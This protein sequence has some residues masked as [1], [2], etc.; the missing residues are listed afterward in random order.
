MVYRSTDLNN[1]RGV[2][3]TWF[4]E[5]GHL[6]DDALGKYQMINNLRHY[7]MKMH[8]NIGKDMEKSKI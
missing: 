6:I 7:L 3:A 4:H 5:H 2:G 8:T 1:L